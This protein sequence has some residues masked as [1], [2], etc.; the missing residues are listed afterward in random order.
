MEIKDGFLIIDK[1]AGW[2]SHDVVAKMRNLLKT[3]KV[4]HT[5]TLDPMATG[6]LPICFGRGTK[7]AQL[8]IEADKGYQAVM[9]LGESTDTQDATG[10]TIKKSEIH[11]IDAN[12]VCKAVNEFLGR[13]SQVP[14]MYSA[15][16]VGGS[17]LY[18]RAR[19]GEVIDRKP[20]DIVIKK[21]RVL[22][23]EGMDVTLDIVC[24][25]GTYIRTL[26]SDIG[27][28]I[29]IGAHLIGL[30]RLRSGLFSID[31]AFTIEQIEGLIKSGNLYQAAYTLD[32][33]LSDL[34]IIVVSKMIAERIANGLP[35]IANEMGRGKGL[36]SLGKG[37][38]FRVHDED[39]KLLA[40]G[41]LGAKDSRITKTESDHRLKIEKVLIS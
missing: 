13:I 8:L 11:S 20:R 24:S 2:T 33:V 10:K 25:K 30:K 6:V 19:A 5:G 40:I 16:K 28:R 9:R 32:M 3:K 23:I 37:E 17:P 35:S 15:V 34:P 27:D 38:R 39:G 26:C 18:K 14:P 12:T 36:D 7:I 29:G 21:I 31:K 41:S 4:G 22:A 1:P